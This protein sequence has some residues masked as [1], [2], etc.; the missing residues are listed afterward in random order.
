MRCRFVAKEIRRGTR[1][2]LFAATPPLEAKKMLFSFA[3]TEG[4]GWKGSRH[5]GMKIDVVD[6]SCAYLHA[7]TKRDVYIE[8]PEED[9]TP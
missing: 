5:T 8:L 6:V 3:V 7:K 9:R 1:E 2:D 4:I